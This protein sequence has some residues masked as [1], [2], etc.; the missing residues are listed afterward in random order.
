MGRAHAPAGGR[1][2]RARDLRGRAR[3]DVRLEHRAPPRALLRRA[4]LGPRPAHAQHPAVPGRHRLHRQPRRGRGRLRRPLAAEGLLAAR[5][6]AGDRQARGRDGR[7]RA[8]TRSPTTRAC[9]TTRR[10]WPRPSRSTFPE[11]DDENRAAAMCYTSG[12][13]GHPKGVV[14]SHRSTVLHSM[15]ALVADAA[16][17]SERDIVMPVVPMFHANAWGLC[18]AAVMAGASLALPGPKMQPKALAELMESEKVTLAAGVP[19]IWMGVLPELEGRDLS[20]PTGHRLRRVRR[21]AVAE[22]GLPRAGRAA[23]PAGLGHDRD[24][25]GGHHGADQVDAA[26]R[27]GGR[28]GRPARGAGPGDPARGP[29]DRRARHRRRAALGRRGARRAAGARAVDRGRA[30]TTT[31]APPTPSPRTAGCAPATWRRSPR[32]ATSGSWTAPRTS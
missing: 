28:A 15:G 9:T 23:D 16:A 4:L 12:T 27:L 31:S 20:V 10:C 22:R 6:P 3:R 2:R 25:A 30:T 24:L 26:G 1:A 29:A 21:A 18:Q 7:R 14:Y 11:L 13:T 32:T 17:V 19:T 5:G 8:A